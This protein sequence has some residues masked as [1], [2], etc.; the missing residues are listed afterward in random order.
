MYLLTSNHLVS[1]I[2]TFISYILIPTCT[3]AISSCSNSMDEYLDEISEQ[4]GSL[5]LYRDTLTIAHWNIG[6][7]SL[8]KSPNTT[9]SSNDSKEKEELYKTLLDSIAADIIGICEYNPI[10]S[11]YGEETSSILFKSY[12]F[13][14]I[15]EKYSYNCNAIFSLAKLNKN[16]TVFFDKSVQRRY[17]IVSSIFIN[18]HEILFV[19]SHLDWNQGT[20]GKN[21]RFEQIHAL[22]EQFSKCP[23]VIICADFNVAN[24]N[25]FQPFLDA[26][27]SLA[28]G[29][30]LGTSNTYTASNP[31]YPMDNIITK[32][33]DIHSKSIIGDKRL[34]DHCLIK[35][36]MTFK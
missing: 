4:D 1:Y 12:P 36:R 11:D 30:Q 2:K 7:F 33:L 26:G 34:S 35:A 14:F 23:Y 21:C 27:F 22:I 15:G 19:E 5:S 32:G 8:G 3:L 24:I 16:K 9:I 10:F 31:K 28:N 18:N 25:E 29:E 6:H 13:K 17:Y 20:E